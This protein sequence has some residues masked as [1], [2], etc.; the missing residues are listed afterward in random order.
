MTS[1]TSTALRTPVVGTLPPPDRYRI[2]P[3]RTF[4]ELVALELG[5]GARRRFHAVSGV[6]TVDEPVDQSHV[7]VAITAVG[8]GEARGG[9]T[10]DRRRGDPADTETHAVV[11]FRTTRLGGGAEP[12][13]L[14]G[15]LTIRGTDDVDLD[16]T[17]VGSETSPTGEMSIVLCAAAK[18]CPADLRLVGDE[19]APSRDRIFGPMVDLEVL[20]QAT[21]RP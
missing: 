20:L 7:T 19:V 1:W 17:F 8:R 21:T 13:L 2:I 9:R 12:R 5:P 15:D 4:V 3:G 14:G 11:S 6:I 18:I 16:V 10:S